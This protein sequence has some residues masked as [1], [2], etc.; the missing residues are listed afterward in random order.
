MTL[1][2]TPKSS[3]KKDTRYELVFL[4]KA[5]TAMT[6]DEVR[7]FDTAPE[8]TVSDFKL[9]SNTEGCIYTNNTIPYSYDREKSSL[10]QVVT[11]PVSRTPTLRPDEGQ[12]VWSDD[13]RTSTL[14][15][16]C[17]VIAD[18]KAYVVDLRLNPLLSYTIDFLP[19]LRDE[20]G[21]GLPKKNTFSFKTGP[22]AAKDRYLYSSAE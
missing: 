7:S 6:N 21:Q 1:K 14:K 12:Y 15:Y 16:T 5:S 9:L 18:K 17:P 19:A 2:I 11:S 13:G 20:Y 4:K 22:I 3:F 8:F 10:P